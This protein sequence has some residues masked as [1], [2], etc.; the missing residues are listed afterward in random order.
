MRSV[1]IMA[2][3]LACQAV[4]A[5][6]HYEEMHELSLDTHAISVLDVESGAGSINIVGDSGS[7]EVSVK[8]TVQV[9]GKNDD[10]A[11]K[12]IEDDLVLTLERNGDRAVLKGYFRQGGGFLDFGDSPSV[13]LD[14][15]LP[16]NLGLE[17]DDGSGSI[18]IRGVRGDIV[19]DDGSGSITMV[20]VGGNVKIDDGSGSISVQGV[21]GDISIND[22]SGGITVRGVAGSV[23]VDDGSGSI[24]V[25]EVEKD[26][27]I[28]N[29]GSGGLDFSNIAGHVETDS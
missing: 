5:R 27:T 15:R 20:D 16:D 7:A 19:L 8:A 13:Q 1:L 2:L 18:E 11:R 3:I 9:S 25:S 17:V 21:G 23:I 24:D 29:S 14:V 28:V 22:G 12:K 26:L 4:L 6:D 10:K